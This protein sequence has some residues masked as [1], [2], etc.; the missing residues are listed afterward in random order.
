MVTTSKRTV[1]HPT[2]GWVVLALSWAAFT[3]TSV[4]RAAW[5]PSA[6]A[7]GQDFGVSLAQTG[8]FATAHDVGH[9]FSTAGG[10]FAADCV[11]SRAVLTASLILSGTFMILFGRGASVAAGIAAQAMVGLTA[12]AGLATGATATS[13]WFRPEHRGLAFATLAAAPLLA[14]IPM[15]ILGTFRDRTSSDWSRVASTTVTA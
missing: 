14:V 4:D 1:K 15:V 11:G 3:A 12:G 8:V 7:V 5:G 13:S 9:G 2:Y 6:G 10:G